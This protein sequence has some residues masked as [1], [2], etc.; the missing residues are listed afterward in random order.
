M[1]CKRHVQ[2]RCRLTQHNISENL[3][4]GH[5]DVADGNTQAE[6]L[7][8]LEF[9]GRF[10]LDELVAQVFTMRDGSGELPSWGQRQNNLTSEMQ[11]EPLERP[12]PRRRGICLIRASDARKASYF[13]AS[14]LTSFLFLLSLQ[15]FS[16]DVRYGRM[17]HFFKS[18]TDMYSSS[19]C[20]ARSMSAAS[21]RMQMDI[22]GRGTLGSLWGIV[23]VGLSAVSKTHFTVP[24]KRL[25][26]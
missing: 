16:A 17:T 15:A 7:L 6:D 18:S 26:R 19:I 9:D 4:F 21:A 22:R 12:G 3:V 13:L 10:D 14:F 25:S 24:E 1:R 23:S 8:Q 20:L 5:L 2:Y 11:N